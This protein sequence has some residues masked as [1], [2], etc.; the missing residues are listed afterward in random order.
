[1]TYCRETR[2]EKNAVR[3]RVNIYLHI[4]SG[5]PHLTRVI[6]L[7]VRNECYLMIVHIIVIA[8][9]HLISIFYR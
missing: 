6:A 2:D 5:K 3:E 4:Y 7:C 9:Q 8:Q 1:M